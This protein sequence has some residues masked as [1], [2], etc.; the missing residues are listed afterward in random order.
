MSET[1]YEVRMAVVE[2]RN[3]KTRV[4]A[5]LGESEMRNC[6]TSS[7]VGAI[8]KIMDNKRFW[9]SKKFTKAMCEEMAE[10]AYDEALK[11]VKVR[12]RVRATL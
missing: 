11:I 2:K 6:F 7:I 3:G 12:A 10:S 8:T 9:Q 4:Q 1:T 5:P